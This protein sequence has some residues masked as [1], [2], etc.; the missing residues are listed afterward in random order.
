MKDVHAESDEGSQHF[1]IQKKVGILRVKF[2]A[3]K[4]ILNDLVPQYCTTL[5]LWKREKFFF[6]SFLS[7]GGTGN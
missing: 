1:H 4:N 7:F 2:K 6:L 5:F 3:S